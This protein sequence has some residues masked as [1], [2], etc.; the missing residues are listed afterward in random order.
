VADLVDLKRDAENPRNLASLPRNPN[1]EAADAADLEV[2]VTDLDLSEVD[3]LTVSSKCRDLS[4]AT[5]K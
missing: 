4:P 5:H 1:L 2:L 3:A